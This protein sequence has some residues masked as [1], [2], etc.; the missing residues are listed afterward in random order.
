MV[1]YNPSDN[2]F[3]NY[4]GAHQQTGYGCLLAMELLTEKYEA[5]PCER[6]YPFN[7]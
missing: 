7:L 2:A 3:Q 6:A 5:A 4:S 1:Y